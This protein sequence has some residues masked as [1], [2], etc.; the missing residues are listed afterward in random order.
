[1]NEAMENTVS[2]KRELWLALAMYPIAY[3]YTLIAGPRGQ[4][5]FGIFVLL[6]AAAVEYLNHD[7]PRTGES[8]V[9][10][11]CIAVITA[12]VSFG[13]GSVWDCGVSM[14]FVHALA[15]WW[16]LCRSGKLLER[17]SGHLLPVDAFNALLRIPFGSFF[18]RVRVLTDGLRGERQ[19]T[20]KRSVAAA[21]AAICLGA[22]LLVW[23]SDSLASADEG[24]G[25]LADGILAFLTPSL[26]SRGV[27]YLMRFILSLPIAA[28]LYGL[29]AG[30]RQADR[31]QLDRQAERAEEG[32]RHLRVVPSKVW[33]GCMALF[34]LVYALFF[35]VQGSYL[36]GAFF[37]RLPEGFI[38]SQYARQGFFELCRV[39]AINLALLWLVTRTGTRPIRESRTGTVMCTLL[40]ACGML[41][42]VVALSKLGL[43]ISCFGF[44]PKRLMSCY[45]A[46]VLLA[47]SGAATYTLWSGKKSFRAWLMFAAIALAALHLV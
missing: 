42:A 4:L 26:R 3:I 1:M 22:L 11:G 5:W 33:T 47:G 19:E 8:W 2:E 9:W 38:V 12:S 40:L 37:R 34:V 24:F 7:V 28:W 45:L 23:V 25:R 16:V 32:L 15:V 39:M 43:Y 44:T 35:A 10:L 30:A 27:E 36:F 18:L 13:W 21:A 29:I 20:K 46:A 6:F 14:L 17:E 41:L 31:T